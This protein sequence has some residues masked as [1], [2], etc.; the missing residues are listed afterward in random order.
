MQIYNGIVIVLSKM[1]MMLKK[2]WYRK[3]WRICT[4]NAMKKSSNLVIFYFI[5]CFDHYVSVCVCSLENRP[6]KVF[7]EQFYFFMLRKMKNIVLALIWHIMECTGLWSI[8]ICVGHCLLLLKCIYDRDRNLPHWSLSHELPMDA[9]E[10]HSE[11]QVEIWTMWKYSNNQ[12]WKG[13]T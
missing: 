6:M 7:E 1:N 11:M 9:W 4:R 12:R 2:G 3:S 13:F 5:K 10:F 8:K